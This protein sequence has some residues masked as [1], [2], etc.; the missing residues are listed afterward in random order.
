MT[1]T[2]T[3]Q[4]VQQINTTWNAD[5]TAIGLTPVL[6]NACT[7]GA[8]HGDKFVNSGH[9]FIYVLNGASASDLVVTINDQSDCDHGF[10]HSVIANLAPSVGRML[11]PFP[12]NWFMNP[13]LITYSG[14][15][16]GSPTIA[17]FQLPFPYAGTLNIG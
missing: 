3:N 2:Y 12:L 13:C 8:T 16:T 9:E 14:D 15:V 11:G 7:T 1:V 10:N 4:P 5:P 6:N 17:I